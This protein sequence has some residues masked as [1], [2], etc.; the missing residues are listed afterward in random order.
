M[1]VPSNKPAATS[2]AAVAAAAAASCTLALLAA[3]VVAAPAQAQE[4]Q[5]ARVTALGVQ[6]GAL[7]GTLA[8]ARK[9][10]S[11]AIGYRSASVPFSYLSPRGEP[12]GY[13][14][15][16]CRAI[17]ERMS[18]E[19][20]REL[21]IQWVPVTSATRLA[22]IIDGKADLE[23]GSTTANA[24]REKT[25]AFSP[26]I[27]V[28]GTKLLVRK[29]SG[30]RGYRDLGGK[31]V[32]VTAGTTNDKALRDVA[33]RFNVPL[34]IV[35]AKD[36]DESYAMLE[37][38]KV[39]AFA[40]DDVLL[41]G[42][43]A[44]HNARDQLEVVGD[45]LS[46]DPYGIVYRRGDAAMTRLVGAAVQDFAASRELEYTYNKWFTKQLPSGQR[47]NLPMSAQLTEMLRV[48]GS[49]IARE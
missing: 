36:H 46:Y 49:D 15:D 2:A 45:F 20:D 47:L 17:V 48:M 39:D 37:S 29:G 12:I 3:L 6:P 10:G 32:V 43:V 24:E 13:S 25:V 28:S 41:Y 40:T 11:V 4:E 18:Q 5:S 27:F 31:T 35:V 44:T 42:L 30:I 9:S 38:G 16:I 14:I 1:Q 21:T 19:V 22:A 34:E 8:K 33:K 23:C 7:T 26:T